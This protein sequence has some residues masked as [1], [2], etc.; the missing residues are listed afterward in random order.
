MKNLKN[1]IYNFF[2]IKIIQK[3]NIGS[4]GCDK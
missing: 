2:V 1:S 4:L 3:E